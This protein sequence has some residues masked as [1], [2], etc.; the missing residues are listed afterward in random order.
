MAVRPAPAPEPCPVVERPPFVIFASVLVN[1][2]IPVCLV[3]GL[4]STLTLVGAIVTLA[5]FAI[6]VTMVLVRVIGP[7]G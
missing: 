2:M 4:P 5:A 7:E 6:A 3:N 1:A